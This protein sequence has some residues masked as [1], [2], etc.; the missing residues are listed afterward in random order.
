[1]SDP[2][3]E[4]RV[5]AAQ[6]LQGFKDPSVTSALAGLLADSNWS[7]RA[8]AANTLGYLGDKTAVKPLLKMVEGIYWQNINILPQHQALVE[9]TIA[10]GRLQDSQATTILS[11]LLKK[12]YKTGM[13]DWH[14]EL[15]MAAA[16]GLGYMDTPA[17]V[18]M[19]L[20]NLVDREPAKLRE[21]II[22]GLA[23]CRSEAS[24]QLML[25]GLTLGLLED[26]TQTWRRQEGIIIA[27][28]I[29]GQKKA[30]PYLLSLVHSEYPEVRLALA[31]TIVR[32]D[33]VQ[34]GDILINLLR[35][36]MA[37]V[38]AVAAQGLGELQITAAAMPLLAVAQDPDKT[39][40]AAAI[41]SI[42]AIKLLEAGQADRSIPL[43]EPSPNKQ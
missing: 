18:T 40:A 31:R 13:S 38:R 33:A 22:T 1:L 17:A 8:A 6:A 37:A 27:L 2:E 4:V 32:L 3:P 14:L 20:K 35:D 41:S 24:F 28:G 19:L 11:Q 10:L 25:K 34:A 7:V 30:L 39:V 42:E 12:G 26:K 29:Q 16:I 43:L 36:R 9:A 23:N 21:A 15:R 5:A